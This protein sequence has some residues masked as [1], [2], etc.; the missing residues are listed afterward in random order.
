MHKTYVKG[1][2]GELLAAFDLMEKG[3]EVARALGPYD[4]Y[5]LVAYKDRKVY[6][7]Q[8][9]VNDASEVNN[10]CDVVAYADLAAREVRYKPESFWVIRPRKPDDGIRFT[11]W[12]GPFG[13]ISIHYV[14]KHIETIN[15]EDVRR[16]LDAGG[17]VEQ[18]ESLSKYT[19]KVPL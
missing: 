18:I 5:D 1:A 10:H 9:K 7:I 16:Y 3:F 8:V 6:R 2:M 4:R 12:D 15:E 13:P 17:S 14:D 11:C 19:C